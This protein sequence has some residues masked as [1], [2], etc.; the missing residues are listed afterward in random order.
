MPKMETAKTE[1]T[2]SQNRAWR[3]FWIKVRELSAQEW[4]RCPD[5]SDV[6]RADQ[7]GAPGAAF[8]AEGGSPSSEDDA[9]GD[10][11]RIFGEDRKHFAAEAGA[12]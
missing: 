8:G 10:Q 3:S 12:E 1:E 9:A 4:G 11:Y 2:P 7:G 5:G 6:V